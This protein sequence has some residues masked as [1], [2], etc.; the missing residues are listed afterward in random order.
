MEKVKKKSSKYLT[1]LSV[2]RYCIHA[3][4]ILE[5]MAQRHSVPCFA[6]GQWA[7]QLC[8]FHCLVSFLNV[9]H[10]DTVVLH[11]DTGVVHLDTSVLHDTGVHLD[12]VVTHDTGVHL[13][14]VG[15]FNLQ[16]DAS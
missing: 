5:R 11:L 7:W 12:T 15:G 1:A 13:T 10:L 8:A 4:S 9:V 16:E 6:S 14:T 2:L 3:L